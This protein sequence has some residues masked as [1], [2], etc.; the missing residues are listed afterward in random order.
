VNLSFDPKRNRHTER[1]PWRGLL[2]VFWECAAHE[3]RVLGLR[4]GGR[5]SKPHFCLGC[6][7]ERERAQGATY[8]ALHPD[9]VPYGKKASVCFVCGEPVWRGPH[10]REKPVCRACRRRL[11]QRL[12]EKCGKQFEEY[13]RAASKGEQKYCSKLCQNAAQVK[14]ADPRDGMRA[15]RRARKLNKAKTWD[16]VPDLAVFERALWMCQLGPWCRATGMP[17]DPEAPKTNELAPNID[18]I[19]PLSLGGI[20]VSANKRAAHQICNTMRGNKMNAEEIAFMDAHPELLLTQEQ[21]AVLPSKNRLVRAPKP[22]KPLHSCGCG[23]CP[24]IV[25]G[26]RA[27]CGPACAATVNANRARARYW[28]KRNLEP[29]QPA[30]VAD[31]LTEHESHA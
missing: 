5:G 14:Y 20:D 6:I 16:G 12:C 17:I 30:W 29:P 1:Y 10:S 26:A 9:T 28:T 21:L 7:K 8:D 3:C 19:I 4:S 25:P 24:M 18:H 2:P 15:G 23:G 22:V 13:G 27:F 11:R 31:G